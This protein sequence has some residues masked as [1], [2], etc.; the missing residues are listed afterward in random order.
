M[1]YM[2]KVFRNIFI[3][4]VVVFVVF[5][6][7]YLYI[8]PNIVNNN[9]DCIIKLFEKKSNLSL[10]Y[11][12]FNFKTKFDL[13]CSLTID[14]LS[15]KSKKN[16]NIL[17]LEQTN[18]AFYPLKLIC[19][20]VDLKSLYVKNLNLNVARDKNGIFNFINIAFK[21][22]D[23]KLKYD[24]INVNLFKY[25][26]N[27]NDE[28]YNNKIYFKG[29]NFLIK[30]YKSKALKVK[31]DG[32]LNINNKNTIF[33]FEFASKMPLRKHF[34]DEEFIFN[35]YIK[36][37]DTKTLVKYFPKY[38]IYING[39]LF[40]KTV[41]DSKVN[42][43]KLYIILNEFKY[44]D[45]NL[46][47]KTKIIS[48][49]FLKQN[50]LCIDN[51]NINNNFLDLFAS[52]K[53]NKIYNETPHLNV[54]LKINDLKIAKLIDILP[55]NINNIK[56]APIINL[57]KYKIF[58]NINGNLK[59]QGKIIEPK[60]YG[61]ILANECYVV[62]SFPNVPKA[63]V[64]VKFKGDIFDL[65]TKVYTSKN[66]FVIVSGTSKLYDDRSGEY[67]IT[68]SNNVDLN[69]AMVSLIPIKK[70]IGFKL[71]PLP[72]MKINGL[73]NIDL[74]AK[75]TLDESFLYGEFNFN[76]TSVEYDTING[77]IKNASGNLVFN[78]KDMHFETKKAYIEN[79][80]IKVKGDFTIYSDVN[81]EIYSNSLDAD[82][83]KNLITLSQG[84]KKYSHNFN[85]ISKLT[86]KI[87]IH[88]SLYGKIDENKGENLI[89]DLKCNCDI[90]MNDN[91]CYLK[92]I[93]NPISNLYG[94]IQYKASDKNK[95]ELVIDLKGKYN[96][97]SIIV[98]TDIKDTR[99]PIIIESRN[100]NLTECLKGFNN[101]YMLNQ[102]DVTSSLFELLSQIGGK[103]KVRLKYYGDISNFDLDELAGKFEFL[104]SLNA[105]N[106]PLRITNGEIKLDN[107]LYVNNLKIS[108]LTDSN[109]HI[110][111][112]IYNIFKKRNINLSFAAQNFD[113]SFLNNY[114]DLNLKIKELNKIFNVYE[115]FKGN[116]NCNLKIKNENIN[117]AININNLRF[118]HSILKFPIVINTSNIEMMKNKIVIKSLTGEVD[119][120]PLFL[121]SEIHNFDNP[122]IK[123]YFT[124]KL[125]DNLV[126]NA[127]NS[128]MVYPIKVKGDINVLTDFIYYD[129][130]IS[131]HPVLRLNEGSDITYMGANIGDENDLREIRSF[132]I[133]DPRKI[134]L[135]NIEYLKYVTS[136]NNK[137]NPLK[138]MSISGNI[139]NYKDSKNTYLN[140]IRI[141][142]ETS[143]SAKLLNIFLK[144]SI[145][146]EGIFNCDLRLIGKIQDPKIL[147]YFDILNANMPLYGTK[148]KTLNM[149]FKPNNI[150][151]I[152]STGS[153]LNSDFEFDTHI[154]NNINSALKVNSLNF[155]LTNLNLSEAI[156]FISR[157]ANSQK[158]AFN[159]ILVS[160][161][162]DDMKLKANFDN[163]IIENA[164]LNID[165]VLIRNEIGK[166]FHA[167]IKMDNDGILRIEKLKIEGLGGDLF[168][169][170]NYN[171]KTNKIN[172]N[173]KLNHLDANMSARFLLDVENQIQGKLDGN[174]NLITTGDTE[175]ERLK[176]LDGD[177]N[178][179]INNGR[180]PK[181]GSLEYL[182][183][184]GN[185][186]KRGPL[187]LTINNIIDLVVPIKTG[188][189]ARIKGDLIIKDSKVSDINIYSQGENM[190]VYVNGSYNYINMDAK[191]NVYGK[192]SPSAIS[193]L[194]PIG[195]ASIS[196]L[197]STIGKESSFDDNNLKK[198][199]TLVKNDKMEACRYFEAVVDGDI[200][201]SNYVKSFKWLEN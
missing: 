49:V 91:D 104:D 150:I 89:D 54:N 151:N 113:L 3:V 20:T 183:R 99:R 73:G 198:I 98:K 144:K 63:K 112:H 96:N 41:V 90:K 109:M 71:G 88:L 74:L 120:T 75:G 9:I 169:R 145:F 172:T 14:N 126:T 30:N 45:I 94:K 95:E 69:R 34:N 154:K 159:T 121:K 10:N 65:N 85:L 106:Y 152:N 86:K 47:D 111:G 81:L 117:G 19:K 140:N 83:A 84:L 137:K 174:V 141:K 123:G 97:D 177:I 158:K 156:N 124:F 201:A 168:G 48:N 13:S 178:F 129:N 138:M 175:D 56:L 23:F 167:N 39:D 16:I 166:D 92:F 131:L 189:F 76:N 21:P 184:A 171:L 139:S 79:D 82:L 192:L 64:D 5:E 80:E 59:I 118:N 8:A 22:M 26:I 194:G 148:I 122:Y 68:S 42:K 186:I 135:K 200:N 132:I 28:F 108:A 197:F 163:I 155:H 66:E 128:F 25:D 160:N 6:G 78:G 100:L 182:L 29:N 44:E 146:K 103:L 61:N 36:N 1:N 133:L 72:Y 170:V 130:N 110:N 147:G 191:M 199:P 149:Q 53:V 87:G 24:N 32:D 127:I 173:L 70:I 35:G 134:N 107:N 153:T 143:Q 55:Q 2:I 60:V 12:K 40:L 162:K 116:C 18:F 52:G 164:N 176:N 62:K 31:I 11:D 27:F 50:N 67:K 188:Y 15:I 77:I 165:N 180:L 119:K 157:T 7:I 181:L 185:I 196:S 37:F 136:Q 4:I 17:N 179:E 187:G 195:N 190:S 51:L 57:K 114:K 115:N 43:L 101:P 105:N 38:P 93:N 33:D 58:G 125:T 102:L 193:L 46:K 161:N 142:T